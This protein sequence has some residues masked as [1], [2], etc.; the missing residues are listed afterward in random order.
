MRIKPHIPSYYKHAYLIIEIRIKIEDIWYTAKTLLNS[1]TKKNFISQ[2]LIIQLYLT[3][4]N[5][6]TKKIKTFNNY[7][8]QIYGI[9]Q[10]EIQIR[11]SKEIQRI[12]LQKYYAATIEDI[13]I[14]LEYP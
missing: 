2:I 12:T 10:I 11:N 7:R 13:N 6:E 3:P 14:I 1:E 8:I 5:R 9:H 4:T